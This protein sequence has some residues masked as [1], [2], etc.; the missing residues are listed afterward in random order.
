[1]TENNTGNTMLYECKV[2]RKYVPTIHI[3]QFPIPEPISET[4]LNSG[5]TLIPKDSDG[6]YVID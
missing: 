2:C 5:L 1:M 4:N 3:H 6:C